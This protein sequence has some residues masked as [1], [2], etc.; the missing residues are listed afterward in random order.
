MYREL[1]SLPLQQTLALLWLAG[2]AQL[3]LWRVTGYPLGSVAGTAALGAVLTVLLA[4]R[5]RQAALLPVA[6]ILGL[7]AV[8]ALADR[9]GSAG[10]GVWPALTALYGLLLWLAV[11]SLLPLPLSGR[12]ARLLDLRLGDGKTS[13]RQQVE[14]GVHWSSLALILLALPGGALPNA[15]LPASLPAAPLTPLAIGLTF[16]WLAGQRYRLR[17]HSYLFI[18][19][20]AWGLLSLYAR[21]FGATAALDLADPLPGLLLAFYGLGAWLVSRL[22]DARPNP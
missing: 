10:P 9:L 16:L 11:I 6:V 19:L 7:L 5:L 18:V 17:L 2:L 3:A 12:V 13:G 1:L 21:W 14:A 8:L 22:L 4:G 20:G 15:G